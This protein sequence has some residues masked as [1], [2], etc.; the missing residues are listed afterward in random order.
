MLGRR[1]FV[2]AGAGLAL[3]GTAGLG[4]CLGM[5]GGTADEPTTTTTTT[6]TMS[7]VDFSTPAFADG[8]SIPKKHTCE[9]ADR[10]PKLDISDVPDAAGSLALVVDDP[11]APSGTF[12]H[13][14]LWGIA[15]D[16]T[17]IPADIPGTETVEEL[18]GAKQGENDFGEVGYRGPCPPEGDGPHTYRFTLYVLEKPPR[19]GAGASR[20]PLLKELEGKTMGETQFTGTFER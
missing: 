15:T 18:D 17:T 8:A 9:G 6:R 2:R 3:G 19:L 14:L 13:W 20:E 7:S 12:T 5:F 16:T 11:D 1:V 10:S 4:G